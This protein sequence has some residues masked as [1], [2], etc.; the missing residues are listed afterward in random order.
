[1]RVPGIG[2]RIKS[3]DNRDARVLLLQQYAK[4][5]FPSTRYLDYAVTVEEYTLQ[6]WF[7]GGS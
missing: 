4:K 1:M 5:Y 3:K 6:V 2:H 7:L